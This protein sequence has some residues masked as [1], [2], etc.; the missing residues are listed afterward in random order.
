LRCVLSMSFTSGLRGR[1]TR[2]CA[3]TRPTGM[4]HR[5]AGLFRPGP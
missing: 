2:P 4:R 3:A 5:T 1:Y